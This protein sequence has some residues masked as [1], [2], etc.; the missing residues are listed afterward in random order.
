MLGLNEPPAVSMP[1]PPRV[2]PPPTPRAELQRALRRRTPSVSGTYVLLAAN[3]A[4][5]AAVAIAAGSIRSFS[6]RDLIW[7][8]AG[9][10]PRTTNGEWW[11]LLT[12]TVLHAHPPHLIFN[13]IALLMVG[14]T[15]E[16]LVG[17]R[18]FVAF[19]VA[20]G[21]AGSAAGLWAHPLRVTVGAS[22]AILGMYGLLVGLMFEHRPSVTRHA[23]AGGAAGRIPRAQLQIF[24]H[25]TM[26]VIVSAIVMSWWI[27][28]VD[29]AGH[30]GGLAAGCA[31]GW[32]AGKDIEWTTAGPRQ[33][34]AA[35]VLGAVCCGAAL[36]ASGRVHELRTAMIG[37]FETDSRTRTTYSRAIASKGD[38]A[39]LG[40][41]IESDILPA[42]AAERRALASHGRV[43]ASQ[44]PV[45]DDLRQ[46]VAL[47]EEAW[48]HRAR[49]HREQRVD[50]LHRSTE[51]EESADVVMRR[52][53]RA[54]VH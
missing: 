51:I 53:L 36:G 12:A 38:A 39:S 45:L 16:R 49:G 35:L 14:P 15:V 4:M 17:R 11:R 20:C 18:A 23:C 33:I 37:V 40:I 44:Q 22:G 3:V 31:I 13:M 47:Q 25:E 28:N 32:M 2:P 48:R 54:R 9:F 21:L 27:P 52:L 42:L 46:Y 41:L 26:G 50:L 10:G 29:N 5:F 19:Y 7:W 8:G 24:L 43:A 6:P 30:L 34:A 1:V